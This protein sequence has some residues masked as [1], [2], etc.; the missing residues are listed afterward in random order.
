[1]VQINGKVNPVAIVLQ[2]IPFL[3]VNE[4]TDDGTE[5]RPTTKLFVIYHSFDWVPT[6]TAGTVAIRCGDDLLFPRIFNI[7]FEQF[8]TR[9]EDQGIPM[10]DVEFPHRLDPILVRLLALTRRFGFA[11]PGKPTSCGGG[12]NEDRRRR[13]RETVTG[14]SRRLEQQ[15]IMSTVDDPGGEN[16][17]AAADGS[18]PTAQEQTA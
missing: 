6:N 14:G 18:Q 2:Q 8:V 4:S 3:T 7:V 17:A 11:F 12:A 10:S 5:F 15:R 9:L 1:M 13:R 16:V